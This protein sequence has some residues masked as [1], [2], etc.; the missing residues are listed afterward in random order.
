MAKPSKTTQKHR[1]VLLTGASGMIGTSLVRALEAKSIHC[2]KMVRSAADATPVDLVW[3][4]SSSNPVGDVTRLEEFDAV[5]H[6]SG[7]NLA[8][9]R[10]TPAYKQQIVESRVASTAALAR[11]LAAR[12][13]RLRVLLTAS[14]TGVYGDRGEDILTEKSPVGQGFLADTC[15]AWEA[16]AQPAVNAG[17]RVAHLRFGVVL[18]PDGGAFQKMLPLFRW[19]LGGKLGNG[20]QWM[21]WVTLRDL[22]RIVLHVLEDG[23]ISGPVNVVA[24][25]PVTNA[26]FTRALGHSLHRPAFLPAPAFALRLA[27]GEIAPEALLASTRVIPAKLSGTGFRFQDSEIDAALR[28]MLDARTA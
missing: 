4:P 5:I 15:R 23:T 22:V 7:A 17:I 16:A 24:P 8:A 12:Q 28:D 19:G 10:W 11:L 1:R 25:Y 3:N 18:A 26:T 13:Q 2:S 14:A 6:L 21:S 27:L 9:R 20:H